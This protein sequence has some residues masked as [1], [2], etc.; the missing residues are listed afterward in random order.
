ML[1]FASTDGDR[2]QS[3]RQPA[4]DGSFI[5]FDNHQTV[6]GRILDISAGGIACQI[7]GCDLPTWT[8][9]V[10]IISYHGQGQPLELTDVPL[11]DVRYRQEMRLADDVCY[12]RLGLQFGPL[13]PSQR[14][15]I[16]RFARAASQPAA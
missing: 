8:D 11:A 5:I 9:R 7:G 15:R 12:L 16:H 6:I 4:L 3:R 14:G 2:R 10:T 1:A 13:S